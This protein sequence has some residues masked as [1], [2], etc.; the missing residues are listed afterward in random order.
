MTITIALDR[1]P[2]DRR[3]QLIEPFVSQGLLSDTVSQ[4]GIFPM[5]FFFRSDNGL[6]FFV[7]LTA[8]PVLSPRVPGLVAAPAMLLALDEVVGLSLL[9]MALNRVY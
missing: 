4:Q 6:R 8:G 3:F 7:V 1:F 2:R 5:Q 9:L